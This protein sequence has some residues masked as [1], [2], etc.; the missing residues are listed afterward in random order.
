MNNMIK[1]IVKT[2]AGELAVSPNNVQTAINLLDALVKAHPTVD[3]ATVV[4]WVEDIE[5][6]LSGLSESAGQLRAE[7]EDG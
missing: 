6:T 1:S 3:D 4:A 5:R 2:I 7:L